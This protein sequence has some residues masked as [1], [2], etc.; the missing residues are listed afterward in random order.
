MAYSCSMKFWMLAAI[1]SFTCIAAILILQLV[2]VRRTP[3]NPYPT[4]E[5]RIEPFSVYKKNKIYVDKLYNKHNN[6]NKQIRLKDVDITGKINLKKTQPNLNPDLRIQVGT[7]NQR[8]VLLKYTEDTDTNF[9]E[10]HIGTNDKNLEFPS[11]EVRFTKPVNIHKDVQFNRVNFKDKLVFNDNLKL[12]CTRNMPKICFGNTND[13]N[14][15]TEDDIKT[16]LFYDSCKKS[17]IDIDHEFKESVELLRGVYMPDAKS[18]ECGTSK[19]SGI[20][21]NGDV[22]SEE[23]VIR[24]VHDWVFGTSVDK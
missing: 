7:E 10:V 15:V 12:E 5:D 2:T 22:V 1:L 4:T 18:T 21:K 19:T 16:L 20:T 23:T 14:C 13:E 6:G 24:K 17:Y 3:T 8:N 11:K 9:G